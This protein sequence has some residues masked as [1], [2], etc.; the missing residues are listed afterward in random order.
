MK[1]GPGHS[2]IICAMYMVAIIRKMLY[3]IIIE[4]SMIRHAEKDRKSQAEI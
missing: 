1:E 3:A 2:S 4:D